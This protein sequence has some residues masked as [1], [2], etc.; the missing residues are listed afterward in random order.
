LTA[1]FNDGV[2]NLLPL[3]VIEDLVGLCERILE[4]KCG[5]LLLGID[6]AVKER[7]WVRRF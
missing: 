6:E 2:I 7:V 3:T 1:L 4:L 5:R